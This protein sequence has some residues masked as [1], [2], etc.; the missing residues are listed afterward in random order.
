MS[1]YEKRR[2]VFVR[3]AAGPTWESGRPEEQPGWDAHNG[4]VDDLRARG[5]FVMGCPQRRQSRSWPPT[6][7]CST[8]SS[9]S[10][11]RE[12]TIYVDE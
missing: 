5:K 1:A 4:F 10:K 11:V 6:R 9:C 8:A 7:S 2:R 12:W 3:L